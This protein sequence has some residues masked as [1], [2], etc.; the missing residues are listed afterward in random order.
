M[1]AAHLQA[2]P[3]EH[4]A[5]PIPRDPELPDM[6]ER[7]LMWFAAAALVATTLALVMLLD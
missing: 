6:S 4:P 1:A 3:E 2:S 5:E 7:G